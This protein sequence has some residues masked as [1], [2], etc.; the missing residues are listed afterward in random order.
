MPLGS[1][2]PVVVDLH[3]YQDSTATLARPLLGARSKEKDRESCASSDAK[4]SSPGR[5]SSLMLNIPLLN[6][7]VIVHAYITEHFDT[8]CKTVALCTFFSTLA[9]SIEAGV[10][11][12]YRQSDTQHRWTFLTSAR[13]AS[14]HGAYWNLQWSGNSTSS[15]AC[16]EIRN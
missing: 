2:L 5:I 3:F 14:E 9:S 4:P 1:L 6:L 15:T 12:T 8:L 7:H 10:H 16:K 11:A 13:P